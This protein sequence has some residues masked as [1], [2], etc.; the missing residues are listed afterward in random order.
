MPLCVVTIKRR[1]RRRRHRVLP[2]S[3]DRNAFVYR[4]T[5]DKSDG[6]ERVVSSPSRNLIIRATVATATR[7]LARLTS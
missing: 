3:P 6:R 5:G 2:P 7:T 4:R 1:R